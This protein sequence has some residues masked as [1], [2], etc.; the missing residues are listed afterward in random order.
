MNMYTFKVPLTFLRGFYNNL[1]LM[2]T[3]NLS[4]YIVQYTLIIGG[5]LRVNN[6]REKNILAILN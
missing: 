6:D 3:V 1:Y 4:V 5:G 2:Y